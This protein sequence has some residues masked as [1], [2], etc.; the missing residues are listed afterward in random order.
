M[1]LEM[2]AVVETAL[3]VEVVAMPLEMEEVA[4]TSL[5]LGVAETSLLLGVAETSKEEIVDLEAV[6]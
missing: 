6:L 2:V 3:V 4:E 1:P 5:V